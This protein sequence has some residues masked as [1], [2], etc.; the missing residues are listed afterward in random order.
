M[1]IREI[2]IIILVTFATLGNAWIKTASA[3]PPAAFYDLPK[4]VAVQ[5]RTYFLNHDLTAQLGWLPSDAFNKGYTVGLSYTT[6]F[7]DYLG[8]EVVNANY[9]FNS[10]TNLKKDLLNNFGA[11]V[12]NVG[13]DGVL[14]FVTYSLLRTLSTATLHKKPPFNKHITRG[15]VS[16]VFGAGGANFDASGIRTLIN[17]GL[18]LRFFTKADTSWKF[19]FRDFLYFEKSLGA[20]NSMSLMVGYSMQLGKPPVR[21]LS[22]EEIDTKMKWKEMIGLD[23]NSL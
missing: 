23:E 2:G 20:V 19:D 7:S 16:F 5:N 14:D 15:E 17:A 18:Y 22:S 3:A 8:W 4:V 1:T 9:S 12:E 21:P 13:F 10:E 11:A 6:F